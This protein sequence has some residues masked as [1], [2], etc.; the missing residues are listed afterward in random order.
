MVKSSTSIAACA[1]AFNAAMSVNLFE[2]GR[3][4]LALALSVRAMPVLLWETVPLAAS[5]AA[6]IRA[7]PRA[8]IVA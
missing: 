4:A 1:I 6:K 7:W 3:G 2:A 8:N 5:A